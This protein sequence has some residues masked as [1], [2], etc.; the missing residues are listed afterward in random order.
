MDDA[1]DLDGVTKR[2]RGGGGITDL[3]LTVRRGEIFGFLGPN[4]AGKT[5]T[6]RLL[7]DLL[8]PDSG[9][10]AL[11]GEDV[12][13]A[14][15]ALRRRI[16]YLPGD[17]NLWGRLTGSQI[18]GH[19]AHLRGGSGLADIAPLAER[20]EL[21]L[22]KAAKAL[23]RGNRQKIGIVQALMGEPDLLIL[24][25]P[26]SGLDPLVQAEFHRCLHEV[27][28]RGGTIFLSS[29]TLSEVDRVAD[30]VGM[31]RD[32]RIA[33]ADDVAA[34]RTRAVHRVEIRTAGPFPD[35]ALAGLA[36]ARRIEIDD[37]IARLDLSGGVAPL[38]R[39]I[40]PLD[41]IDL[42]IHEPDLEDVFL[43]LYRDEDRP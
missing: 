33:A 18:L 32:G 10:I 26:T 2:Y 11:L 41:V 25:E 4:G 6:I 1:I 22:G 39:T 14:G 3:S 17:L 21:D 28:G 16:G 40:A 5:T 37:D 24:D 20:F 19:L 34:L 27:V 36:G 35:A 29:H 23:S 9:R 42:T 31:I 8:R 15:P 30:R 7:V 12:R 43:D 38:L 13:S